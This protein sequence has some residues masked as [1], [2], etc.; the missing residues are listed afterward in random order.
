MRPKGLLLFCFLLMFV[1]SQAQPPD[2]LLAPVVSYTPEQLFD[3][4]LASPEGWARAHVHPLVGVYNPTRLSATEWAR[5]MPRIDSRLHPAQQPRQANNDFV[6]ILLM[7]VWLLLSALVFK[8]QQYFK[9]MLAAT[10]NHRLSMQFAREQ[11]ANRTAASVL[12][13]LL[14]NVLLAMLLVLWVRQHHPALPNWPESWFIGLLFLGVISIYLF[15]YA[16]YKL[17][18]FLFGLRETVS[19]Y[20]SVVFLI[21]RMSVPFLLLA[22]ALSHY[23]R[24]EVAQMAM[25]AG[26][27][28]LALG[29]LWRYVNAIREITNVMVAHVFHF[30]LYFCAVELIPTAVIAKFLLNV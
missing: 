27:V 12:Y 1:G 22:L 4:S 28:I 5:F 3:T 26:L 19:Y 2:T 6:F 24:G 8:N 11:V 21:Q 20:L 9:S 25:L 18:G 23:G 14:F 17:L 29:M 15:K 13:L 16:F 7:A 30:I 10:F